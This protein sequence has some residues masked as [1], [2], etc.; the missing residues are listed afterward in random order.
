MEDQQVTYLVRC[1]WDLVGSNIASTLIDLAFAVR[2]CAAGHQEIGGAKD[3]FYLYGAHPLKSSINVGILRAPGFV[4]TRAFNP[5]LSLR[6][7]FHQAYSKSATDT[8]LEFLP[9]RVFMSQDWWSG[10][11]SGVC[12]STGCVN[13][14]ID[15][16]LRTMFQTYFALDACCAAS[17]LVASSSRAVSTALP[18]R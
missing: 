3:M 1:A 8:G 17:L 5:H 16:G 14:Q 9:V 7:C 2:K 6:L 15:L 4:H 12:S 18:G 11:D 10:Q 13:S